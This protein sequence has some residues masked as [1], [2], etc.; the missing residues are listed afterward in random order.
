M[1][2][3]CHKSIV[4]LKDTGS[5][6]FDEAYF[7]LKPEAITEEKNDI[8]LE[9]NK[10]VNALC[11]DDFKGKEKKGRFGKLVAFLCGT[12]LGVIAT[13]LVYLFLI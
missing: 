10:I 9:A 1:I 3:G 5:K 11:P 8:V 4:F 2:K 13:L 6:I 12:L 7:I